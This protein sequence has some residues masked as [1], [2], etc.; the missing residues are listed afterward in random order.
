ISGMLLN[1]WVFVALLTWSALKFQA[2]WILVIHQ[3]IIDTIFCFLLSCQTF[4]VVFRSYD[5]DMYCKFVFSEF[6]FYIGMTPSALNMAAL[7]TDRFLMVKFPT[8][9]LKHV[10]SKRLCVVIGLMWLVII[11][12][13]FGLAYL[14]HSDANGN[15]SVLK[16]GLWQYLYFL[17]YSLIGVIIPLFLIIVCYVC[18]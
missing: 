10:N 14:Y 4:A 11:G 12:L 17:T 9:H 8:K 5:S 2:K 7:A 15:C 16:E 18:I 6:L 1:V 3:T 13:V